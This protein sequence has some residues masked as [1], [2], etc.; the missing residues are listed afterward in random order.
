MW[1]T[2]IAISAVAAWFEW[3]YRRNRKKE[4]QE[5]LPPSSVKSEAEAPS[6]DASAIV[7]LEKKTS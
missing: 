2:T 3:Q 6:D 1:W 5:K 4:S 7:T